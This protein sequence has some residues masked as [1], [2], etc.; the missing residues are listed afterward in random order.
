MSLLRLFFLSFITDPFIT[1]IKIASQYSI[2]GFAKVRLRNILG[3]FYRT[4]GDSGAGDMRFV[5]LTNGH[6]AI[7]YDGNFPLKSDLVKSKSFH[8]LG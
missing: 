3:K 6:L 8:E 2:K 5:C 1:S 4:P 7:P